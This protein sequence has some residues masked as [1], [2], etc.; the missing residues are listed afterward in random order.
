MYRIPRKGID[1]WSYFWLQ[2]FLVTTLARIT[3][4][5]GPGPRHFVRF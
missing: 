1:V 4:V 2:E 3:P 5:L